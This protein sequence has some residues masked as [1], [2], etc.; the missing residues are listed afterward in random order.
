MMSNEMELLPMDK[1]TIEG[2]GIMPESTWPE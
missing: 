2:I 1:S